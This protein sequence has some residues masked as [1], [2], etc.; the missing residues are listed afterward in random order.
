MCVYY[1]IDTYMIEGGVMP[2]FT[3]LQPATMVKGISKR[4]LNEMLDF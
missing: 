2:I 3:V 4:S 1:R